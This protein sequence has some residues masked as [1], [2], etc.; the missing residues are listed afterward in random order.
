MH[1]SNC[2]DLIRD[3]GESSTDVCGDCFDKQQNSGELGV[4]C[5]APCELQCPGIIDWNFG[6]AIA[7]TSGHTLYNATCLPHN[8]VF[9]ATLPYPNVQ[10][11]ATYNP[12]GSTL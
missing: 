2:N 4:D 7:Q 3:F 12:E 10:P 11:S 8:A 9:P 1:R 6:L 5:G